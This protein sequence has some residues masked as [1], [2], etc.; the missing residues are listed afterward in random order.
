MDTFLN[1][2]PQARG[3]ELA[4]VPSLFMYFAM[5]PDIR[6]GYGRFCDDVTNSLDLIS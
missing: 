2:G 5:S 6:R 3:N 4:R 1:L